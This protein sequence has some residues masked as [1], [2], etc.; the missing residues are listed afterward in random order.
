MKNIKLIV[1]FSLLCAI[2]FVSLGFNFFQ[3][4]KIKK[5]QSSIAESEKQLLNKSNEI[6]LLKRDIEK[7][8]KI[9]SEMP[10]KSQIEQKRD[11]CI[12]SQRTIMGI[13]NCILNSK[14]A[15]EKEMSV[16][17]AELKKLLTSKQYQ[18]LMNSQKQW[19]AYNEAQIDLI[20][21][22]IFILPPFWF[23]NIGDWNNVEITKDRAQDLED[24]IFYMKRQ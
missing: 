8:K 3:Y 13:S 15:W 22:T 12:G 4:S 14:P 16:H 5:Q 11:D 10:K 2:L 7:T 21:S 6:E 19:E 1:S 23:P 18:L 17:L 24:L 9:I 20:Y